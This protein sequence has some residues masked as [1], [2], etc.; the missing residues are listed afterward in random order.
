VYLTRDG[1]SEFPE[2]WLSCRVILSFIVFGSVEETLVSFSG[3]M[4]CKIA[5]QHFTRNFSVLCC[6]C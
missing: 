3:G 6:T 2:S 1:N 5:A 4:S